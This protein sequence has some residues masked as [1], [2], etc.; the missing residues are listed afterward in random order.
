ME[1]TIHIDDLLTRLGLTQTQLAA[2]A[3][4]TTMTIW[5][6]RKNGLPKGGA[7]RAFIE[8]LAEEAAQ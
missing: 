6:W 5:R 3:G 2:K 8:R 7:A 4:V 1:R